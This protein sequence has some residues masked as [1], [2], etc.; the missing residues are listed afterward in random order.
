MYL[1]VF[2]AFH[3]HAKDHSV[4]RPCVKQRLLIRQ[5]SITEHV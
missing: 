1:E 5:Q 4:S 3:I 2:D